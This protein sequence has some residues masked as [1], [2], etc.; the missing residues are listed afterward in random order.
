MTRLRH[1][2]RNAGSVP[3]ERMIES[4]I[5]MMALVVV[6]VQRPGLQLA[7]GE[8]AFVHHRVKWML[9]VITLLANCR[10]ARNEICFGERRLFGVIHSCIS[11]PS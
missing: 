5:G 11:I 3:R 7:A 8:L 4:L 6:A 10:K 1:A 2:R 9:V